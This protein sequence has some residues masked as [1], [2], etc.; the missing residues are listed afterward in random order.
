M[1]N[2]PISVGGCRSVL[3][4]LGFG[5]Q[6][7]GLHCI[8]WGNSRRNQLKDFDPR[9]VLEPAG[10]MHP[11]NISD[12]FLQGPR[13][14]G[15]LRFGLW[16]FRFRGGFVFLFRWFAFGVGF[17]RPAWRWLRLSLMLVRAW[18]WFCSFA[19]GLDFGCVRRFRF[20]HCSAPRVG[21]PAPKLEVSVIN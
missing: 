4:K 8:P 12:C 13:D 5:R 6:R 17:C 9:G 21:C 14:W 10:G 20:F 15:W 3:R 19:F 11:V 2:P 18:C 7:P 1:H 16:P